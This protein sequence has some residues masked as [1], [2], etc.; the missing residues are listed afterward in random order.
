MQCDVTRII[1]KS[2]KV[3]HADKEHS[4]ENSTKEVVYCDLK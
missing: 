4:C 1:C 2:N 3:E